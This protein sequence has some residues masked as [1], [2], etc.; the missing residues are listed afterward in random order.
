QGQTW[1]VC[2]HGHGS[3]GEQLYTRQDI[4]RSW[5]PLFN[6]HGFGILTP[7]LRGNAWMSPRAAA[8][9]NGLLQYVRERYLVDRFILAGGSMGG[10]SNLIYAVLH[11][12][13]VAGV[14]A[15]CPAADLTSYYQWCRRQS[16]VAILQ[17]IADAIAS[18]YGCPPESCPDLYREHSVVVHVHRL[19]MPVYVA[20]GGQDTIIPIAQARVLYGEIRFKGVFHF[21][22]IPEGDHDAPLRNMTDGI[23][24]VLKRMR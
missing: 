9:L 13:D 20:H 6:R 23:E 14:V 24:W 22:E 3:T 2:I 17:Q 7:N 5:L 18:A 10:T 1:V 12:E 19:T 16:T 11:P 15:L 4:R 21:C 8:D